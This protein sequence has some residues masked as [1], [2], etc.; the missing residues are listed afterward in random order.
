MYHTVCA[1]NSNSTI[2]VPLKYLQTLL[3]H[4]NFVEL[5]Y[6][7]MKRVKKPDELTS[8]E[9]LNQYIQNQKQ[10][11]KVLKKILTKLRKKQGG[12]PFD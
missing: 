1:F 11:V 3:S 2:E 5:I 7:D 9:S 8:E 12:K 6:M 4:N 10:R